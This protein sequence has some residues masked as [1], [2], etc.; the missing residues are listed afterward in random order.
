MHDIPEVPEVSLDSLIYTVLPAPPASVFDSICKTLI[1]NDSI[2]ASDENP[3]WK[4]LPPDTSAA[5]YETG[6]LAFFE[7]ILLA[8]IDSHNGFESDVTFHIAQTSL[9]LDCP[10]FALDLDDP[11]E[12]SYL[13]RPRSGSGKV[14]WTDIVMAMECDS[15]DDACNK[16]NAHARVVWSMY[17]AMRNDPRRQFILGLTCQD[18]KARLWYHDRCTVFSSEEFDINKDWTHL[19]RILISVLLAPPDRL[20]VDPDMELVLS[21]NPD[22]APSYSITIRNSGT[23]EPTTYRTLEMISSAG[24]DSMVGPGTRL[25]LVQKL[26]ANELHGPCYTLKDTWVH[27]DCTPEHVRLEDIRTTQSGYSQY[28]PTPL[29]HG[30]SSFGATTGKTLRLT[31]LAPTNK[32]LIILS[33]S[34]DVRTRKN[35]DSPR[36]EEYRHFGDVSEQPRRH[37]RIVFEEVGKPV[38]DLCDLGD[39]FTAILGGLEGVRAMHLC[40]YVHR[41]IS[42][43]NI[44][45]VPASGLF[46]QRGVL[47]GLEYAEKINDTQAP[48]DAKMRPDTSVFMATEVTL[49][50]HFRLGE[51]RCQSER[52]NSLEEEEF[53]DRRP[54]ESKPFP[55]FSHNQ[56]HDLESI[57]WV[58]VWMTLY[59]VPVEGNSQV[60]LDSFHQVFY[61]NTSRHHFLCYPGA[62]QESTGHLEETFVE[63]IRE[64]AISLDSIYTICYKEQDALGPP[65]K[66]I[67]ISDQAIEVAYDRGKGILECLKTSYKSHPAQLVPLSTRL[68]DGPSTAFIRQSSNNTNEN[69]P[70]PQKGTHRTRT[71]RKIVGPSTRMRLKKEPAIKTTQK[72][73]R[74][75]P[76]V[77]VEQQKDELSVKTTSCE[78]DFWVEIPIRKK[79]HTKS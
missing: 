65:L 51:L 34:T 22:A 61:D 16:F 7:R 69:A 9:P 11:D 47:M 70:K 79:A 13:Q 26:V 74:G 46:G 62:F 58:C 36:S 73:K 19:V 18:T 2:Q 4:C 35:R 64:W 52:S 44:L 31:E 5:K 28:F 77:N 45:L 66:R 76:V 24:A 67:R 39:V 57:W 49:M 32:V 6:S 38:E 27:E 25:W 55:S 75:V 21:R 41:N 60:Q 8:T 37:Y 30:F 72:P 12:F 68:Y 10:E 20:G 63:L 29:D 53:G 1:A 71:K 56:L 42:S 40:K 15:A 50:N 33:L 43:R 48:D 23:G 17:H 59:L 3:Q 78:P 54:V 14:S